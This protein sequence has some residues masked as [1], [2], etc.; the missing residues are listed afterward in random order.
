MLT[1]AMKCIHACRFMRVHVPIKH[2][3]RHFLPKEVRARFLRSRKV[4]SSTMKAMLY[5]ARLDAVWHQCCIIGHIS[6]LIFLRMPS[7]GIV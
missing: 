1:E 4:K 5:L 3:L 7:R 6:A 2:R